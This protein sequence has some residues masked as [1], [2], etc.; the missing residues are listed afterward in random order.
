MIRLG[1]IYALERIAR[2]SDKD[3]GPIMEVLTAY[4][5]DN[6]P[7]VL[8]EAQPASPRGSILREMHT[9][10]IVDSKKSGATSIPTDIQA[11]LTV[12][13]RR[14]RS[15]NREGEY[16]LD[17]HNTDLRSAHLYEAHLEGAL[18]YEAHLEEAVLYGGASGGGGPLRG[19]S[20]EG[21]LNEAHLTVAQLITVHTLYNASLDPHLKEEIQ[22]TA[23]RLLESPS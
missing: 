19:A 12:I 15:P 5:R 23:P 9:A 3:H 1:G 10:R 16:R 2:D 21:A 14:V 4:V 7:W 6:A 13:G 20:G 17:L 11:I 18:L 8:K 22:R